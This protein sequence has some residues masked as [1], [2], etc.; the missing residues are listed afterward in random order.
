MKGDLEML[1]VFEDRLGTPVIGSRTILVLAVEGVLMDSGR[2]K[3]LRDQEIQ[4]SSPLTLS[5]TSGRK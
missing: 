4:T 1:D 2:P 3:D 5:A